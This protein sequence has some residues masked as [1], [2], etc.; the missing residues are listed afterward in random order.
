ML[1][2]MQ[3]DSTTPGQRSFSY[4]HPAFWAPFALVGDGRR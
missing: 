2:L 3:R 1:A 4:A